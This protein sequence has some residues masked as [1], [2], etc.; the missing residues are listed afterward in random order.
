MGRKLYSEVMAM[1]W[2]SIEFVVAHRECTKCH[3]TVHF[4]ISR[5]CYV[6]FTSINN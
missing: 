2:N 3:R 5:L 1:L 6:N 4:E